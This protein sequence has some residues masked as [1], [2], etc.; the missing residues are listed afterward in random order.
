MA[1]Q[2]E[3]RIVRASGLKWQRRKE[4]RTPY[5]VADEADVKAGYLPKTVNLEYLADNP[6]ML[7]A[8]CNALQAD[9]LLWRSGHRRDA[10]VFD[11]TIKSLLEIYEMHPDSSFQKIKPATRR[12]YTFYMKR[13]HGHIGARR[14]D[15]IDG[16]DIISWHK[17]WSAPNEDGGAE[18][19]AA[20]AM[21]RSVLKA[22]CSFGVLKRLA[23]A[24]ELL[25]ILRLSKFEK[26]ASRTQ[27]L[28]ADQVVAARLAAH[29]AG[30]PARALAYA[31][32][33]ET[34]MRLWD[35]IGQW[36][37]MTEPGLSDVIDKARDEKWFGLSWRHVD[38]NMVL[39]FKPSKTE[40]TTGK[41]IIV[42]LN[43]CPMVLEEMEHIPVDRR[44]G[45]IVVSP[46]TGLPYRIGPFGSAWTRDR[47]AAGIPQDVW[48]RDL[49]ASGVTEGRAGGAATDDA[50]KVAGHSRSSTT[51][52]VYDRAQIE[53][54]RRFATA[55]IAGRE[56]AK[57]KPGNGSGSER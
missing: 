23:G 52:K 8:K 1:D 24:K 53:A 13:L 51:A 10:M 15:A 9:M 19:L 14:V 44:E 11:G 54:Q 25:E 42:D 48:A 46:A 2:E 32:A 34:L 41:T 27:V 45:P 7:V 56:Q 39:T 22:A 50:A 29:A 30:D 49:R 28:T 47:K 37:P 36:V 21:A 35:V 55:R 6:E 16:S 17:V 38:Q 43:L 57:N 31:L 4:K 12:P 5:W 26:P 33:F 3:G 18:K 40:R 20:A